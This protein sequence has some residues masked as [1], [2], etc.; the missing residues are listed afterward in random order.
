MLECYSFTYFFCF[1]FQ[2]NLELRNQANELRNERNGFE[3][4]KQY[5]EEKQKGV[6]IH[7]CLFISSMFQ[8]GMFPI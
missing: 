1:L 3:K 8:P 4:Q 7:A 6:S 2:Q 5:M